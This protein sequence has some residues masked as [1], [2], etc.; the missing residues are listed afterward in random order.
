MDQIKKEQ[1]HDEEVKKILD[2]MQEEY[3]I[4]K[5]YELIKDNKIEFE[6]DDKSYRVRLLNAKEKDELDMIR[7]KRFGQLL[8]DQDILL[9]KDLI[10]AYQ[11][12]GINIEEIDEDIKK[13]NAQIDDQNYKLGEALSKQPGDIILK[14]YKD[15]IVRL[16]I[17]IRELVIQKS[18]LLEYSLENQLQNFVAQ[19]ISYLCLE[20][21]V[22][23]EWQRVFY[24]LDD[25][26]K[27]DDRLINI[28]GMY[29]M[30]LHYRV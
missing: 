6:Y 23:N 16:T 4:D 3:L 21:K 22:E 2:E 5:T 17:K 8:K 27:Q 15:E 20:E 24:S 14:T 13:L 30:Y 28:V 25:F 9:E 19:A 1:I 11:E 10:I 26:L 7:R 29:S 12:R 18:H